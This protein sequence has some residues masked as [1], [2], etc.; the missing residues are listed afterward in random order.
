MLIFILDITNKGQTQGNIEAY[1]KIKLNVKKGKRIL[2]FNITLL[3]Q[4]SIL[5]ATLLSFVL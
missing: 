5:F 3:S 4:C 2:S 1:I